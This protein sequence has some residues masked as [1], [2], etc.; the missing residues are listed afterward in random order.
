MT[1]GGYIDGTP[2]SA[3]RLV[4]AG[5]HVHVAG[6]VGPAFVLDAGVDAVI[7]TTCD[8]RRLRV[9]LVDLTPYGDA[10]R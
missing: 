8:G 3:T 9:R 5:D 4:R 6:V 2:H 7:V 10:S 1:A